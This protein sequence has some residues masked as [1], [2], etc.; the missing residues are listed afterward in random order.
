MRPEPKGILS[1]IHP[2]CQERHGA[3][4]KRAAAAPEAEPRVMGHGLVDLS[5]LYRREVAAQVSIL[6]RIRPIRDVRRRR[7]KPAH[8]AI[9][10]NSAIRPVAFNPL[11]VITSTVV[12]S[13]PIVPAANN[14]A[15]P[16]TTWADVGST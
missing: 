3:A 8:P 14:F 4:C 6:G 16:A 5:R 15:N 7:P 12:S 10:I 1:A 2:T 13:A 9:P 11:P